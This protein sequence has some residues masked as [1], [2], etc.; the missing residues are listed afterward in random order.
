MD[1]KKDGNKFADAMENMAIAVQAKEPT[2]ELMA[3]YFAAFESFSI[4]EVSKAMAKAAF[5]WELVKVLPP[6]AEIKKHLTGKIQINDRALVMAI[7]IIDHVHREGAEKAPGMSTVLMGDKV[8]IELMTTRWPYHRWAAN[9]VESEEK[10]WVKEFCEAYRAF[11]VTDAP[12]QIELGPEI[13][14]LTEG[15]GDG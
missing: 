8:A 13:K 1:S 11:E 9:L 15:I 12:L 6:I 10:W 14:K 4:E 3:M 5:D 2:K 7:R